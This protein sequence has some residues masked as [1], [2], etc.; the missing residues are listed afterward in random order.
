[1]IAYIA[2]A[3]SFRDEGELIFGVKM[4]GS[5]KCPFSEDLD[6]EGMA[7]SW[8]QHFIRRFQYGAFYC[9]IMEFID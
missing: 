6:Q 4:V 2:F 9:K 1:M 8:L 3:P 7:G 5:G